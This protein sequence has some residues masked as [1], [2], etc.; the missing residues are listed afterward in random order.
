MALKN[1]KMAPED[2]YPK[3]VNP[4]SSNQYPYGLALHLDEPTLKKLGIKDIPEV[5][6]KLKLS[7]IVEVC[8]TNVNENK[9]GESRCLGLQITDMDLQK[10]K[11][12]VR[13]DKIY[14]NKG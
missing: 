1:M 7:A 12:E 11:S 2:M 5:G 6:Q 14:D 3:P 8:S 10:S 9:S 13:V 4:D